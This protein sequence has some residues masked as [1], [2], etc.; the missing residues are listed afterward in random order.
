MERQWVVW[1]WCGA[2]SLGWSLVLANEKRTRRGNWSGWL[3]TF[4][5]VHVR[6]RHGRHRQQHFCTYN[7]S[8]SLSLSLFPSIMNA[9]SLSY[10]CHSYILR[11]LFL[12]GLLTRHYMTRQQAPCH[13]WMDPVVARAATLARAYFWSTLTLPSKGICSSS[14]TQWMTHRGWY[15]K[16]PLCSFWMVTR[17]KGRIHRPPVSYYLFSRL[18]TWWQ[19]RIDWSID[20]RIPIV[21]AWSPNENASEVGLVCYGA[22]FDPFMERL[23]CIIIII[24]IIDE[25]ITFNMRGVSDDLVVLYSYATTAMWKRW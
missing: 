5:E 25:D 3:A 17:W 6:V 20:R 15:S 14:M 19:S 24:I 13:Q 18:S 23:A 9:H 16:R 4:L 2:T 12:R 7:V 10:L 22:F 11:Q 8:G 21:L 1:E